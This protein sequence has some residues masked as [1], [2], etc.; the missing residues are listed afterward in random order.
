MKERFFREAESAGLLTHPNIVT[1]Y[2]C[3]EEHDLA[4]IAM[5]FLDGEDLEDY[6]SPDQLLPIMETMKIVANVADA[7]DYAHLKNIVHRD[8]KPANIM[9]IKETKEVKVTDFGIARITSSSQTKTG[10]V[11]GTPSYMS[12]E[13]VSGKKVDGRSDVFSLGVVLFEMLTGHKPFTGEDI[14]SLM[15]KIAK[16]KHPSPR[17]FNQKIPPVLEKIID[18]ALEKELEKRYQ[19][20]GQ[21]GAHLKQVIDRMEKVLAQKKAKAGQ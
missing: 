4:Y 12:P 19:R 21:M 1:I 9:R 6:T 15:F 8:I 18:K 20:A 2:D 13:Q 11:L 7:L 17:E 14:T 16:E 5:E 3:G 10:V